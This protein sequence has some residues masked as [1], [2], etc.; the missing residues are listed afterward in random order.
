LYVGDAEK[1]LVEFK[2]DGAA[3][4]L[5][6]TACRY[7]V[8]K[9]VV[10]M[11]KPVEDDR[12][13]I[14]LDRKGAVEAYRVPGLDAVRPMLQ[15]LVVVPDFCFVGERGE[16]LATADRDGRIRLSHF[17]DVFVVDKFL[18]GHEDCTNRLQYCSK[19][20]RLASASLDGTVR[21]WN[22]VT[23]EE[24]EN[25]RCKIAT[26]GRGIQCLLLM[27]SDGVSSRLLVVQEH[28]AVIE[29]FSRSSD[30]SLVRT[31]NLP[32]GFEVFSLTRLSDNHLIVFGCR[33]SRFAVMVVRETADGKLVVD[34]SLPLSSMLHSWV[35]G[36]GLVDP[37]TLHWVGNEGKAAYDANGSLIP[38]PAFQVILQK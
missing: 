19:W 15:H 31:Q 24:E 13:L 22:Y 32:V 26:D 2:I 9:R 14:V 29:C 10:S 36:L 25:A 20:Q 11:L 37:S 21:L 23:G 12:S 28:S 30:G 35:Q 33:D 5:E 1:R 7:P 3:K 18:M 4:K 8:D 16:W 17:P 6:P 38:R 27:P 34:E